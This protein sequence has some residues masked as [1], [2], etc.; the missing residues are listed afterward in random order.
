MLVLNGKTEFPYV[1]D[2]GADST[3]LSE[4]MLQGLDVEITPCRESV[5]LA[6]AGS[7]A[8]IVGYVVLDL[9]LRTKAGLVH[10]RGVDCA[11]TSSEMDEVLVGT[12]V[13]HRLG[14]NLDE[15]ISLLAVNDL[16]VDDDFSQEHE[17]LELGPPEEQE[18]LA[19]MRVYLES[20]IKNGL[21]EDQI[22]QWSNLLEKSWDCFRLKMGHDPAA[23]ILPMEVHW[24]TG[25]KAI[26]L[27]TR[28]YSAAHREFM[29][30]Y[31]GLL[32]KYGMIY[33]N[34]RARYVSPAY[35]VPKLSLIHI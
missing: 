28:R 22:S 5:Q 6:V 13:L 19:C 32:V 7:T 31:T 35:V 25:V 18:L 9:S 23:R 4:R 33:R 26:R 3:M 30:Y 14:I 16:S 1:A 27:S 12:D 10:I 8:T 11:I 34:P 15:Q 24:D 29:E 21:P 17:D 20:S 2:S